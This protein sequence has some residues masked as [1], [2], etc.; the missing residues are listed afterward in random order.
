MVAWVQTLS[1]VFT[2]MLKPSAEDNMSFIAMVWTRSFILVLVATSKTCPGGWKKKFQGHWIYLMNTM[3]Q[4]HWLQ[5]CCWYRVYLIVII[6]TI[7]PLVS[8]TVICYFGPVLRCHW[9]CYMYLS[10]ISTFYD[11]QTYTLKYLAGLHVQSFVEIAKN[12]T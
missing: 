10:R 9:N 3:H 1:G 8:R 5:I 11:F 2:K 7:S 6:F 12:I 4:L